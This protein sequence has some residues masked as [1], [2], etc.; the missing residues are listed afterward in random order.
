MKILIFSDI[1]GNN[2]VLRHLQS[3][4]DVFKPEKIIFLGDLFG[5]FYRYKSIILF[6]RKNNVDSI[7]GNHDVMAKKILENTNNDVQELSKRYGNG[8]NHLKINRKLYLDYLS[9]LP[10][11]IEMTINGKKILFVHGSPTDPLNGRIYK[12]SLLDDKD[13][14]EFDMIFCGHT[15]HRLIKVVSNKLIINVGSSGQPRDGLKPSF[16][17]YDSDNETINFYDLDFSFKL[18]IKQIERNN[19][20]TKKYVNKLYRNAF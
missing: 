18:L 17:I 11:K 16:V 5:Y 13:F 10:E 15:H 2:L 1:H 8:Y 14:K 20:A 4:I 6:F 7:L 3:A 9:G 12:D 19:D